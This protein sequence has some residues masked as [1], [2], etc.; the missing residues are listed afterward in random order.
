MAR[1]N[2]IP[3]L[4]FSEFSGEWEESP[5]GKSFPKIRNGFV[6]T[7]TPYYIR[8]GVPYLQGKNIKTGK[9][10]ADGLVTVSEGFHAHQRKSQLCKGD[11][12]M[13]QS[14]HVGEC[15]TVTHQ[16]E[17]GNCHALIVM[18]PIEGVISQFFVNYFYSPIGK[19]KIQ[20]FTTGNTIKHILTSDLKPL[21][22]YVPQPKEQQKIASFLSVVDRKLSQLGRKKKLLDQYKKSM[23]Q[24]LFT[25]QI[26]FK[27][28]NGDDYSNWKEKTLDNVSDIIMGTSPES[29]FYNSNSEGLPLIQGNADIKDRKSFPRIFTSMITK[30]C[31]EKDILL[32]VRAPVGEISIS[33]HHACI[34][35]GICAIRAKYS[36]IQEFIYQ[37]LLWF[38]PRWKSLSQGS[39]FESVNTGD[40][41]S[42]SIPAPHP[43]EQTK[44]ANFLSSIDDKINLIET[45][46]TKA[47]NFKKGLLQQM[48]V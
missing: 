32:S 3:K 27:D 26:R 40:I 41:K 7:A 21:L 22:T 31:S 46:L 25:Q 24:K 37:F 39:T 36:N 2:N 19:N 28:D 6:G 48:F 18:S 16:Y 44:I 23:M 17:G 4:R 11:I 45:E 8:N 14:G 35:R 12:L 38:E 15:A 33:Q 13:V 42:L 20:K 43:K 5:L 47:K 34:G 9:I 30:E 29:K 10:K 1:M